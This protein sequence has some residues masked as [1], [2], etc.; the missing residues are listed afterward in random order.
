GV[1]TAAS[2]RVRVS[3][4]VQDFW[5]NF[6]SEL[7]ASDDALTFHNWPR[8][9]RARRHRAA[10]PED[11]HRLWFAP[12][13]RLM[14]LRRPPEYAEDPIWSLTHR[15]KPDVHRDWDKGRPQ[16]TNAQGVA[17]TEEIWLSFA[18]AEETADATAKIME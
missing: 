12:E 17:R 10:T 11:A 3:I 5:Q 8:H 14:D 16:N 7:S 2:D 13:C 4:G 18:P 15:N 9:G 6:P 1:M